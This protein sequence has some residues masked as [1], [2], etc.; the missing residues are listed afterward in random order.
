MPFC[1]DGWTAGQHVRLRV[2]FNGRIFESHPFTILTAPNSISCL[3]NVYSPGITLGVRAVGDWSRALNEFAVNKGYLDP[4]G[5]HLEKGEISDS[6]SL[7][8]SSSVIQTQ[9]QVMMDGP[10]GGCSLDLGEYETVL[11]LAGGAGVTFTLGM[12]DDIVGR[13]VRLGRPN[14]E[15]TRRIEFAW[16]IKSFGEFF[17][18]PLL[19]TTSGFYFC[20]R[21]VTSIGS[22]RL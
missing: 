10:Y 1:T 16:C 11:L 8:C 2:F 3:S 21:K 13:C 12:L 17:T 20:I 19:A 14:G 15:R 7:D 5:L 18:P 6:D 9:V 4:Q 22:P